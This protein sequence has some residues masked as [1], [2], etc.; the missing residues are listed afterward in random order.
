MR[1]KEV[2]T[3]EVQRMEGLI[4]VG[5]TFLKS[6]SMSSNLW[7]GQYSFSITTVMNYHKFSSLKCQ[8]YVF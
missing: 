6:I 2:I 3:R 1:E 5:L 8:K 7:G 4:L